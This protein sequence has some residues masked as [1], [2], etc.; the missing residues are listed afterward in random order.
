MIK[1]LD[2]DF[3]TL[4]QESTKDCSLSCKVYKKT[5]GDLNEIART[6][7]VSKSKLISSILIFAVN[8]LR[9]ELRIN[10]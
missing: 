4:K 7:G 2:F 8:E 6:I 9:G 1:E 10:E 5:N 3:T